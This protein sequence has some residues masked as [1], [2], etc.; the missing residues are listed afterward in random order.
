MTEKAAALS[1]T[2]DLPAPIIVASGS[3]A[4]AERIVRIARENGV[5]IVA[6]DKLA[7]T[8]CAL[9][10]GTLIPE[11]LYAVIAEILVFTCGL[12]GRK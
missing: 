11:S 2:E 3:G 5:A 10:V 1:Y 4:L 7:E 12:G 9:E 8:L 6:D